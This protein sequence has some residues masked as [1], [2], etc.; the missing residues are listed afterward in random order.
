MTNSVKT[1]GRLCQTPWAPHRVSRGLQK[2]SDRQHAGLRRA[3]C[4][5]SPP[6]HGIARV[7]RKHVHN[8]E[9]EHSARSGWHVA[10]QLLRRS[11]I[12]VPFGHFL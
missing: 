6:P 9:R 8:G 12:P 4:S 10:S 2:I 7:Y 3:T 11:V 1:V 5:R